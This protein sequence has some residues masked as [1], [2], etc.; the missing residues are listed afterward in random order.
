MKQVYLYLYMFV[1]V[2]WKID[3]KNLTS[4]RVDGFLL[5]KKLTSPGEGWVFCINKKIEMIFHHSTI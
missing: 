2:E 5:R 1:S 3:R 4:I